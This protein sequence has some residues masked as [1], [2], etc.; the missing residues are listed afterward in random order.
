MTPYKPK[1]I[2]VALPLAVINEA[3]AKEKTVRHGHPAGIH[4][5]WARRP[6]A[7]ARAVIWASLVDDPSADAALTVKEQDEERQR[8]FGILERLVKWN[9]AHDPAVLI[10]AKVEIDRCFP[11][12]PPAVLDPFG[13]GGAI[14]LEAQR[15][16]LQALSGDLNPVAVLIQKSI[17][18]IP[19]RF[20]GQP[21]V[22]AQDEAG[23]STWRDA[24]GLAA[25]VEAY[26]QWMRGEAARRIG[27]VY[28]PVR[29]PRNEDLTPIA[30]IWAR[31]VES[32]DPAWK[33]RVPLVKSWVVAKGRGKPVTWVEAVVD[34]ASRKISYQVRTGGTPPEGTVPPGRGGGGARC[35]ATGS[36]I[37]WDYIREESRAGRLGADLIA[38][39]AEGQRGR[40]YVSPTDVDVAAAEE[41]EADSAMSISGAL[42]DLPGRINVVRYG[43]DEFSKLFTKRQLLALSTFS[44]LLQEV[45]GRVMSDAAS[46]GLSVD[47]RPFRDG[48]A[49]ATAY[50]D[51]VVTYLAFAIDKLADLGNSLARWEPV[52][53]CPRQLFGRQ[54]I[55]MVWDFAEAN[56]FSA[57]SG[58]FLTCLRGTIRALLGIGPVLGP[59]GK[60]EQRD[61]IARVRD[62]PAVIVSTDPPYYDN[63]TYADLSDFFYVW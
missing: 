32:P 3:A 41:A 26:G 44:D 58:S 59:E 46:A 1:L 36:L 47:V 34:R 29:G 42:F 27:S 20:A 35:L 57:S 63:V 8:L 39:A 48:G 13:G 53:Q 51:A 37:T 14:P 38:V 10:E 6:L 2:E 21:P 30:W 60:V 43:L 40:V 52:A 31:T 45:H 50:A 5:W 28:P 49:G 18:E 33:G 54:A 9:G 15:L 22:S 62:A 12:G 7:A 11:D 61:A 55:P 25:D 24:Q 19:C 17:V 16:G 56:P 23:L 4:H